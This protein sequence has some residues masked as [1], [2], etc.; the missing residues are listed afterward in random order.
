[1]N[2]ADRLLKAIYK[3]V[4]L[5]QLMNKLSTYLPG[6][7]R[8][9]F[10]LHNDDFILSTANLYT[11]AYPKNYSTEEVKNLLNAYLSLGEKYYE[12]FSDYALII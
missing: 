2:N 9:S 10:D 12:Y 3:D 7:K 1:M 4:D 11:K 6:R 8:Y 5:E